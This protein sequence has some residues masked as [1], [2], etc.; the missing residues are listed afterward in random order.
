M[1]LAEMQALDVATVWAMLDPERQAAI[2]RAALRY[3]FADLVA[4]DDGTDMVAADRSEAGVIRDGMLTG[5][6]EAVAPA[7]PGL[8]WFE[9]L[10]PAWA[11]RRPALEL[12]RVRVNGYRSRRAVRLQGTKT[13]LIRD[14]RA[15]IEVAGAHDTA[16]PDEPAD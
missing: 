5:I 3:A 6:P 14:G 9:G 15:W 13:L 11:L 16:G 12:G 2:G 7:F 4:E 8:A 10:V 1:T